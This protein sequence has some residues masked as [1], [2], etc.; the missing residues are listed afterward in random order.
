[1]IVAVP[2][3]MIEE[4]FKKIEPLFEIYHKKYNITDTNK[5]NIKNFLLN[6]KGVML[7]N[8]SDDDIDFMC[9]LEPCDL[10]DY[11]EVTTIGGYNM[12][13]WLEEGVAA[14]KT[15][16]KELNYKAIKNPIGSRKGWRRALKKYGFKSKND[17][18]EYI[19]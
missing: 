7:L 6:K 17:Y 12:K 19:I 18:M 15:I 13:N 3:N 8:I 5:Q 2:P 11:L 16:A 14:I 1:M 4:A 10:P 9:I